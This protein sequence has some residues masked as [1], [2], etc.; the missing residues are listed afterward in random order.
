MS[1][2]EGGNDKMVFIERLNLPHGCA[3]SEA[4]MIINNKW[5]EDGRFFVAPLYAVEMIRSFLGRER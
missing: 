5:K 2:R 4:Q 3:S 1:R